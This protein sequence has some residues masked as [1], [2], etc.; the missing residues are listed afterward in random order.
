MRRAALILLTLG[1]SPAGISVPASRPLLSWTG[2]SAESRNHALLPA[3]LAAPDP[4]VCAAD[5]TRGYLGE[6]Y[7]YDA[8]QTRAGADQDAPT[9][10]TSGADD[11]PFPLYGRVRVSWKTP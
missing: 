10:L 2:T 11:Q 1:C 7:A 3:G 5:P 8:L 4:H 9:Q 6:L